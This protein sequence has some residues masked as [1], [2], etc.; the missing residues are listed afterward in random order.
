MATKCLNINGYTVLVDE[1]IFNLVK[2]IKWYVYNLG[3][4]TGKPYV[5]GH[6]GDRTQYL[7]R[8]IVEYTDHVKLDRTKEVDHINGNSLDNQ[9]SNLRVC[10][11]C[12]NT[13]NKSKFSHSTSDYI[14]VYYDPSYSKPY[15]PS[16]TH[17]YD[18][19]DLKRCD[20][21]IQAAVI[22][23][24]AAVKY[25]GEYSHLNFEN[26]RS[27]YIKVLARGF[28]PELPERI[29]SSKYTGVGYDKATKKYSATSYGTGKQVGLGQFVTEEEAVKVRD[30][31]ELYVLG[32]KCK[33]NFE[34]LREQYLQQI[35]SG[36]V[37]KPTT[38][39]PPTSKYNGV[40]KVKDQNKWVAYITVDK[41]RKHLGTF[42]T[43]EDAYIARKAAEEY[44][45][46]N[47]GPNPIPEEHT[48]YSQHEG[49]T[50]RKD[51]DK[52]QAYV[53]I[54]GKRKY[55][56]GKFNTEQQAIEARE[57]YLKENMKEFVGL[58]SFF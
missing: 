57:K 35:A 58:D 31:Y 55:V 3:S 49:I 17:N 5:M 51:C 24:L 45:Q 14:G 18:K 4:G 30:V 33:L 28:E 37:P 43:E 48:S 16:I 23:D 12:Q 34:N 40:A 11:R 7:H 1:H 44:L 46:T 47:T 19:I 54:D 6:I 50:F 52:W 41:K 10:E 27:R 39:S 22:R 36:N 15:L 42:N 56:P 53:K 9:R 21:S 32:S 26:R 2:N 8:Y 29:Y 13:K 38:H 25:F 20:T